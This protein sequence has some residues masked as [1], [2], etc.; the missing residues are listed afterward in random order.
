MIKLLNRPLVLAA[1][2][3]C[4]LFGTETTQAASSTKAELEELK[5]QVQLLMQQNRQLNQRITQMEN[6][7]QTAVPAKAAIEAEVSRQLDEKKPGPQINDFVSL[8]GSIEG[9]YKLSQGKDG[10]NKSAFVLDTVE[11]IMDLKVADWATGKIV[12]DYDGD[13]EDRFYLDEAN[14]TLGK[15]EDI[16]FFLTAGKVYVPFGD[17]STSMIQDPLTQNPG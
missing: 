5:A 1:A 4:L 16:P 12:I 3:A 2:S 15:T 13:D 9:D 6:N 17:F 7:A 11:L 8:S 14:I 10:A